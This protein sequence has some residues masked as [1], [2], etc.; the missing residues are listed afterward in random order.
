[1]L[2]KARS[3]FLI[4]SIN[5]K[6]KDNTKD[7]YKIINGIT[8]LRTDN[9]LPDCNN[10]KELANSF[11]DYFINK[12]MKIRENLSTYTKF[13]P[14]LVSVLN[15]LSSF[16][17]MSC[18]EVKN[19]VSMQTKSCELDWLLTDVLKDNLDCFIGI[20]TKIVNISLTRGVFA[21][22]WKLAVLHSLL[23]KLGLELINS[24]Y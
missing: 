1:M 19:I 9:P 18:I 20:I 7:L 23:K 15:P 3:D 13:C 16:R 10:N 11:A 8:G 24:N 2:R 22:D 17:H 4:K 6:K 5:D 12:I 21:T 14:T